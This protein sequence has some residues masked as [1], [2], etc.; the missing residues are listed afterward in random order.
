MTASSK[1]VCVSGGRGRGYCGRAGS[2]FAPR[3]RAKCADCLAALRAD[4]EYRTP[5]NVRR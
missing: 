4:D 1:R 2:E 5:R 3:E